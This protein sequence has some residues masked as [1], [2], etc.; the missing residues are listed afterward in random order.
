M[1]NPRFHG[2]RKPITDLDVR[3]ALGDALSKIRQEERMT[4]ADLGLILG[5]SEDQTAKYADGSAEMGVGPYYRAKAIFNGRFTGEADKLAEAARGP[6]DARHAES[7]ILR[8]ALALSEALEDDTLTDEEIR[9]HRSKLHDARD[10]IDGLL[11]RL[12]PRTAA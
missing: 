12:T 7:A 3:H 11:D 10:M 2:I 9:K 6:V 1:N 5:K 4:W 8:A